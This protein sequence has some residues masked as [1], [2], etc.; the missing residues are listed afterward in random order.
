MVDEYGESMAG[1]G[2]GG[3]IAVPFLAGL[4]FSLGRGLCLMKVTALGRGD[5]GGG[6]L[7]LCVFLF[8]FP[9]LRCVLGLR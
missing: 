4:V 3:G 7:R 5:A 8:F 6:C 9:V 1:G 2:G